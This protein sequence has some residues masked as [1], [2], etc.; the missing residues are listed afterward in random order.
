MRKQDNV[1]VKIKKLTH[2]L[3]DNSTRNFEELVVPRVI[4]V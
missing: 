3:I 1:F 2:E 4:K